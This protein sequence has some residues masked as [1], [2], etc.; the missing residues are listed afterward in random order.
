[1]GDGTATYPFDQQMCILEMGSG[2]KVTVGDALKYIE[3]DVLIPVKKQKD[4]GTEDEEE[5]KSEEEDVDEQPDHPELPKSLCQ[6][7]LDKLQSVYEFKY[8]VLENRDYLKGYLNDLAEAKLAEERA[9]RQAIAQE[10]DIDLNNLDS[11]PDKLVLKQ[12]DKKVRKPRKPRDPNEPTRKR[13]MPDKSIIIAEDSQ[14]DTAVYVRKMITTPEKSPE[15]KSSN[16][17][18]SKHVI[19]EDIAVAEKP[20]QQQPKYDRSM[21]KKEPLCDEN[22]PNESN[23]SEI[24]AAADTPT[25]QTTSTKKVPPPLDEPIFEDDEVEVKRPA[26]RTRK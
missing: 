14:V 19:I 2:T 13:R 10:L 23:N 7:C 18:K 8:R 6:E 5:E 22:N 12:S 9:A 4:E 24:D 25:E 17:R 1:L 26:K 3:L 20:K 15:Q 16:K 21:R 11:L